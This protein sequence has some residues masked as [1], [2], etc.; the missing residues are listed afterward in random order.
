MPTR[1]E[2]SK[3]K[4]DFV[5]KRKAVIY[6]KMDNINQSIYEKIMS[7]LMKQSKT[8]DSYTI[9][10]LQA[11]FKKEF[12][13]KFP[14]VMKET[15]NSTRSL[16]DLNEMYFSTLV[17]SNRL[18][19]IKNNINKTL[20]KRFGIDSNGKVIKGGFLDRS[21]TTSNAQSLFT[22]EVKKIL[23]GNPDPVA[24]QDKIKNFLIGTPQV[25]GLITQYYNTFSKDIINTI[26]RNNGN[27]FADE[28]G[29]NNFYYGGGL[30][31]TSRAFCL[32]CNGKIFNRE[33]ADKW[34]NQLNTASGPIWNEKKD[35]TYD[36]LSQMGGYGC[37]HNPDWITESLANDIKGQQNKKAAERNAAF[38]D[39]NGL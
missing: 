16:V 17:D 19:D 5:E 4:K 32:K 20:D 8:K 3:L 24:L 9:T 25:N 18:N 26:D 15:V 6:S 36:P 14:L 13:T 7:E 28:L 22:K 1:K 27:V 2:V 21:I 38:K 12:E 11:V 30:I 10:E 23:T 39:R 29:L 37:L 34:K 31:L 33:Q 35:G